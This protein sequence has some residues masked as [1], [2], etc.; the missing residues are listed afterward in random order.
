MGKSVVEVYKRVRKHLPKND[1]MV[2]IVWGKIGEYLV[3]KMKWFERSVQQSYRGREV[4]V[5]CRG[6]AGN[7]QQNHR[8]PAESQ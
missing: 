8:T 3:E 5:D 6:S 4:G 7:D 1:E 2:R